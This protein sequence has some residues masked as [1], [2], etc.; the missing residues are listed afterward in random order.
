[1]MNPDSFVSLIEKGEI[2]IQDGFLQEFLSLTREHQVLFLRELIRI[3][4]RDIIPGSFRTYDLR[5]EA[6]RLPNHVVFYLGLKAGPIFREMTL[7][8]DGR[9]LMI[10]VGR[11]FEKARPGSHRIQRCYMNAL[12][13]TGARVVDLGVTT[14]PDIY[15][16]LAYLLHQGLHVAVNVS[17]SHNP[18]KDTGLKHCI[19]DREGF[20]YSISSDQMSRLKNHVL[21]GKKEKI[22]S[23]AFLLDTDFH[24][25]EVFSV[26]HQMLPDENTLSR[27]H[28]AFIVAFGLLGKKAM[29]EMTVRYQGD[30][31]RVL[32]SLIPPEKPDQLIPGLLK[33]F[34]KPSGEIRKWLELSPDVSFPGACGEKPLKDMVVVLDHGRGTA[35]RTMEIY[36]VLGAHV[37]C[38]DEE[39]GYN[40]LESG[41]Q[42]HWRKAVLKA[43]GD[44]PGREVIGLAH[45]EDGDRLA[46]MR[47]DGINVEGDRLLV[48]SCRQ[49]EPSEKK[50]IVITE[51]KSRPETRK[52]LE[53]SGVVPVIAPTGFA[54]IKETAI[55]LEKKFREFHA[56][57]ESPAILRLHG[58]E[59]N[60][61][62]NLPVQMWAELSGH[63][64]L[65]QGLSWFFDDATLMA[66]DLL[67]GLEKKIQSGTR[68]G[69]AL[70]SLDE[71]FPRHPSSGE[72]NIFLRTTDPEYVPTS[73]EKE[74][75]VA[76]FAELFSADPAVD[77][78]DRTD[79]VQIFFKDSQGEYGGWILIRKSNNEDKL[80]VVSSAPT[81]E[82]LHHVEQCFLE[83]ARA[84]SLSPIS[85]LVLTQEEEQGTTRKAEPYFLNR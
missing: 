59:I 54:F 14:T 15:F 49:M 70:I 82:Q 58:K 38:V 35:F 66:V 17:A 68:P 3:S 4:E 72:L 53:D 33:W 40:P 44:F 10:G 25:L 64:G 31:Y 65:S 22:Q 9:S 26:D 50:P 23:D 28:H 43:A 74:A 84:L 61:T 62:T 30:F 21:P 56:C 80:V 37:I 16:G 36:S 75:F 12:A 81:K 42:M 5:I 57:S 76:L 11:A 73:E 34:E 19:R 67:L 48:I 39:R 27:F 52:A 79:G 85:G 8:P 32:S 20:I 1:M 41:N 60:L 46:V 7:G 13:L 47:S 51:V 29:N 2:F 78:L 18:K 6:A 24:S 55:I 63:F 77:H 45:D 71:S 69:R 83:K